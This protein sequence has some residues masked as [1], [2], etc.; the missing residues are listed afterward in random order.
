[1]SRKDFSKD[2]AFDSMAPRRPRSRRSNMEL[3]KNLQNV[4]PAD[5]DEGKVSS[6]DLKDSIVELDLDKLVEFKDHPFNVIDDEE[7][8]E[9]SDSIKHFGGV[10]NPISVRP[11]EGTDQYEII[12]GHRRTFASRKAGLSKIKAIIF[13]F[14]SEADAIT[15]VM[16]ANKQR[17]AKPSEL[18]KGF[19]M[20]IDQIKAEH[21]TAEIEAYLGENTS[22]VY[23]YI[24]LNKLNP[25]LLDLI[26]KKKLSVHSG[27]A[28]TELN[29][30]QQVEVV[31]VLNTF[32]E[33]EFP[34]I[35]AKHAEGISNLARR[36]INLGS[37]NIL[38]ILTGK[39]KTR[40]SSG[41]TKSQK[42][43]TITEKD[44]LKFVP[45]NIK[46]ETP[47]NR[48]KFYEN[49]IKSYVKLTNGE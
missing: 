39:T 28:L 34:T 7:M 48:L 12:S 17:Q 16:D 20:Q 43:T 32:P 38:N 1:M 45:D 37:E 40:K 22:R 18:A 9:L 3:F 13:D 21:K 29:E 6:E 31:T 41:T 23:R 15:A 27:V 44:L 49:A 25:A 46:K 4:T 14:E 24:K 5:I 11:I 47:E 36:S 42:K 35:T 8:K 33:N 10:I 19:K 26:D 30:S 2:D